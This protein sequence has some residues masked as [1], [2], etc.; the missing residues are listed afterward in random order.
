M[1]SQFWLEQY[2]T[3]DKKTTGYTEVVDKSPSF[4]NNVLVF[5]FC[6]INSSTYISNERQHTNK[7]SH[8]YHSLKSS[9]KISIIWI[10]IS[11]MHH[12]SF[13]L[14]AKGHTQSL[15]RTLHIVVN[16]HIYIPHIRVIS[17]L[18]YTYHVLTQ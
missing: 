10:I 17:Y 11:S 15:V 14:K 7:S 9:C 5:N 16:N 1:K 12:C 13:F 4:R 8:K 18:L 3:I 6:D 2:H